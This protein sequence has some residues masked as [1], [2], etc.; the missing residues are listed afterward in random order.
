[1]GF[2]SVALGTTTGQAAQLAYLYDAFECK[3]MEAFSLSVFLHP[4]GLGGDGHGLYAGAILSNI[5]LSLAAPPL[6]AC[7]VYIVSAIKKKPMAAAMKSPA[8]SLA[9]EQHF[10]GV[11]LACAFVLVLNAEDVRLRAMGAAVILLYA[12][13][14]AGMMF[15]LGTRGHATYLP[16][17]PSDV[18]IPVWRRVD[19]TWTDIVGHEGYKK[20]YGSVYEAYRGPCLYFDGVELVF[21]ILFAGIAGIVPRSQSVC[22]AKMVGYLSLLAIR[23]ALIVLK[24]GS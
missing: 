18:A 1:M 14:V 15:V 4:T 3:I 7:L 13:V 5:A 6:Y 10:R 21:T 2:T 20:H 12:L 17:T 9:V 19:G 16:A 24:I 22:T 11:V 23:I 8:M